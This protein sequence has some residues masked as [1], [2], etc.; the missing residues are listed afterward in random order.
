MTRQVPIGD[1]ARQMPTGRPARMLTVPSVL[2]T[3]WML[4]RA[5]TCG[6]PTARR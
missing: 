2:M 4:R 5:G 1:V 3:L 6:M